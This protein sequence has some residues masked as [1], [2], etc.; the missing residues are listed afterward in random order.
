MP[1]PE[2]ALPLGYLYRTCTLCPRRCRVDRTGSGRGI[3]GEGDRVRIGYVGPHFGE[4]PPLSGTMG[5]GTVFF[6]GCSLRCSTCQNVQISQQGMGREVS[7]GQLLAQVRRMIR[8]QKVHNL[9]FVTPDH[10]LPHV[11]WLVESLRAEGLR[12]PVVFNVS[13]YQDRA[14][15]EL[16]EEYVDIY[17][18]D[19]KYGDAGLARRLSSAG[20]YPEVALEAISEMVRQKGFLEV[21]PWGPGLAMRGVLVRHLILPGHIDN[22]L[23]ALS[24]LFV[25]FGKGLPLSLMSQYHPVRPVGE[26]SLEQF[27]C[28]EE[29]AQV[30]E[31]ALSLGFETLYVQFPGPSRTAREVARAFLPDFRK[32][33]PFLIPPQGLHLDDC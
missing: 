1:S 18:P 21:S 2:P 8:L 20:K 29:F 30:Y 5:S 19:F 32:A 16:A 23:E 33:Q 14:M 6:S 11:A 13:G 22:S 31:H 10:F 12:P 25:E 15:L 24:S 7:S 27:L 4:E 3:C 17:L 28:A 26:P 9:N